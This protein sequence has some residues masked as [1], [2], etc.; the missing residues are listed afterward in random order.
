MPMS[1]TP[2][3]MGMTSPPSMV[4]RPKFSS[5]SPHQTWMP[6]LAKDGWNL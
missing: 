3:P 1:T 4:A 6:A 5:G 2:L